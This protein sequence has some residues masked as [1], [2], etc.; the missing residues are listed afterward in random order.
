MP[1]ALGSI[2]KLYCNDRQT[3]SPIVESRQKQ[4]LV[5]GSPL[6]FGGLQFGAVPGYTVFTEL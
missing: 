2:L 5:F 6:H 3:F 1:N 4:A